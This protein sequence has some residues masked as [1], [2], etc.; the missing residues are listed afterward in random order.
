MLQKLTSFFVVLLFFCSSLQAQ[1]Q[2]T[3]SGYLKDASTGEDLYAA[4]VY[5]KEILKGTTTNVYGFY[6]L[7]LKPGTYTMVFSYLGLQEVERLVTLDKDLTLS[8][9][10]SEGEV[11]TAEVIVTGEKQDRNV[12]DA[13]TSVVELEI[14]TVKELPALLGEADIFRTLQ[15]MPG[16]ASAG[17]GNSGLYVRGGGPSQNL[18][19]LDNATVY[20]PGHLLGF[21]S[22]FNA[23]AIKSSTL[24]KGGIPA[25]YGGRISSVLD[26]TMREGNTKEYEFEGGVGFIS[27]R[28]TAQGPIIKDKAAFIISGRFTYLSFLLNPLLKKSDTPINIPW[29][30]DINGKMNFKLGE[31]DRLFISAYFGRDR[32]SFSSS[33]GSGLSF[34]LPYGNATTSIRWNHQFNG[35][36]FMNNSFVFNDYVSKIRA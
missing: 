36:V 29:F 1:N 23:D 10:L 11:V 20:N 9:E 25:E 28:I 32:F 7:S 31:K 24:I 33:G 15:L 6:S 18:V 5:V 22:V 8:L 4:N 17:E 12:D 34:E 19:L 21:F 27:S 2:F 13:Q 26:I 14:K 3:I 30:F 16:V 35:K